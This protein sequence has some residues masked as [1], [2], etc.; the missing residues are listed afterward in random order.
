MKLAL[1]TTSGVRTSSPTCAISQRHRVG[2][3]RAAAG[4]RRAPR[5]TEVWIRQPTISPVTAM[6][7]IEIALSPRSATVRPTSTAERRHR[8]RPEPV[9][10]ALLQVVGEARPGDRAP[11]DHRLREDPGQQELR[12][13]D[14]ARHVDRAAEHVAEQQHEHDRRQRREDDQVG[15]PLDLDQVAPG[16]RQAVGDGRRPARSSGAPC[17]R[18]RSRAR[19]RPAVGSA[20]LGRVAGEGEEH[21]VEVGPAQ[22]D[23]E[24]LH[25]AAVQP[26]QRLGEHLRAAADRQAQPAGLLVGLRLVRRPAARSACGGLGERR[27]AGRR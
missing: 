16:D 18:R 25:A 3:H 27:S 6:T 7:T 1:L 12:V 23:V 26:A 21:V 19:R 22:P 13:A 11:E 17:G 24:H 5:A 4:S 14:V 8:Q 20:V 15:H 10:Q 9:D 2:E